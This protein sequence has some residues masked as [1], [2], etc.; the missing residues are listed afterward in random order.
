[1]ECFVQKWLCIS[2]RAQPPPGSLFSSPLQQLLPPK[3]NYF[4]QPRSIPHSTRCVLI[5]IHDIQA[6]CVLIHI[7]DIWARCVLIRIHDIRVRCVLIR[8]HDIRAR[9]VLILIHD[10]RARC[11]LIRAYIYLNEN[12]TIEEERY[13]HGLVKKLLPTLTVDIV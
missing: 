8:I 7:H 9:C 13:R 5:R 12:S 11:V 1:M 3:F 4:I 10:I 2:C 6:R